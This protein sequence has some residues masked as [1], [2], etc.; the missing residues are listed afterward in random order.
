MPHTPPCELVE[1]DDEGWD[2][3][4]GQDEPMTPMDEDAQELYSPSLPDP[5]PMNMRHLQAL[6]VHQ[7]DD[8]VQPATNLVGDRK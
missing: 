2:L 3:P 4:N 7:N 1:S 5:E 6:G 8:G